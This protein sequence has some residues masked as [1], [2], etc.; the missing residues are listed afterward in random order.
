MN[1]QF[2]AN[3]SELMP[4]PRIPPSSSGRAA[5][6]AYAA[7]T[8]SSTYSTGSSLHARRVQNARRVTLRVAVFSSRSK[9]VIRYPDSVKKRSTPRNP[10]CRWPRWMQRQL[11]QRSLAVRRSQGRTRGPV[12]PA[13][14]TGPLLARSRPCR[15]PEHAGPQ[16]SH[17]PIL[18][19]AR[20]PGLHS[21]GSAGVS[22]SG[23]EVCSSEPIWSRS[24]VHT[25]FAPSVV[26][27]TPS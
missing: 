11:Q 17:R 2:E 22:M 14:R 16:P 19:G 7:R 15:R 5:N 24:H 9:R 23:D 25:K 6:A 3:S 18:L 8:A 13:L 4:G 12:G 21:V 20:H 26:R 1:H 27:W 10:P